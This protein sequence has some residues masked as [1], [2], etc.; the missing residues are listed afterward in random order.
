MF[1]RDGALWAV[2]FDLERLEPRGNPITVVEGVVG[3]ITGRAHYTVSS[4]GS[5]A[6]LPGEGDRGQRVLVWVDRDGREEPLDLGGRAFAYPRLSPDGRRMAVAI[7]E[8]SRDIWVYDLDRGSLSRLTS[9]TYQ[10]E[11]PQ[12]TPDGRHVAFAAHR[13]PTEL[14]VRRL[15][16]GSGDEEV[17]LTVESGHH[18]IG[19]WSSSGQIVFMSRA[20]SGDV[21]IATKGQEEAPQ[22]FLQ[23]GNEEIAPALSADGRWLAYASDETGRFEIYVQSLPNGGNKRQISTDGGTEPLWASSGRE[24]F[25]RN[26]DQMMVVAVEGDPSNSVSP[27]PRAF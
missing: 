2:P 19:G 7:Q 12:W 15:A 13:G 24:L 1:W 26:G 16:D 3:N 11:S 8:T 4:D 5:L 23:T 18:H 6:Y 10:E 25:Y 22:A 20:S 14:I 9:D 27:P 21:W 17:V